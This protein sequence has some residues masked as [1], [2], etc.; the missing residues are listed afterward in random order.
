MS[1]DQQMLQKYGPWAV[2]TGASDGIGKAIAQELSAAGFSLCLV[3]RRRDL[4][5]QIASEFPSGARIITADL[6]QTAGWEEV[7]AST[8]DLDA[9]LLVSAAGF[10]TSGDFI[11]IPLEDEINMLQT[12]CAA[13]L[14]LAHAF[15]RRLVGRGRGGIILFSSLVAFQGVPRSANYAA[16]KAYMQTLAEGLHVELAPHGVDVLSCAPGPVATGF[17]ARA[18]MRMSSAAAAREVARD[19]LNALGRQCTVYPGW[20]TKLRA[21]PLRTLPRSIRIKIM[22][23]AMAAM[24]QHQNASTKEEAATKIKSAGGRSA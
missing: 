18:N 10:G 23:G 13:S 3:A 6:S 8:Q 22:T 19:T 15:S 11:D 7:V 9:G 20:Q 2:V 1:K 24:T 12:N 17:G 14:V 4:L 5:E 21:Y 16:T